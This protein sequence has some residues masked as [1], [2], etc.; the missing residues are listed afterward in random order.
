MTKKSIA[1]FA[2]YVLSLVACF[3]VAL[4]FDAFSVAD[5]NG[6]PVGDDLP[7]LISEVYC[8]ICSNSLSIS[9]SETIENLPYLAF[10]PE[11]CNPDSPF[12]IGYRRLIGMEMAPC[13]IQKECKITGIHLGYTCD[14]NQGCVRSEDSFSLCFDV[15]EDESTE[16]EVN[17]DIKIWKPCSEEI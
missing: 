7:C 6:V 3:T 14:P 17:L 8:P 9:P 2:A 16:V 1:L 11:R 10:Y 15:E 5:E 12:L 4:F 13:Y